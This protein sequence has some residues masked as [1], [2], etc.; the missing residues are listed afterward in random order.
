MIFGVYLICGIVLLGTMFIPLF[1]RSD[2]TRINSKIKF[3]NTSTVILSTL[4]LAITVYIIVQMRLP[5]N[6][7]KDYLFIDPLSLYEVLMVISRL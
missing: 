5:L 1:W 2:K 4:F 3:L 7:F 6:G